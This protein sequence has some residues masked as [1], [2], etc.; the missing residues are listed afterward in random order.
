MGIS[1]VTVSLARNDPL[2][3]LHDYNEP[4]NGNL[5]DVVRL[6]LGKP[7]ISAEDRLTV[8]QVLALCSGVRLQADSHCG[9]CAMGIDVRR[10]KNVV[11]GHRSGKT[12]YSI[13]RVARIQD[14][15][16]ILRMANRFNVRS[17]VVDIRP[18]EDAA[19]MFQKKAKFKVYLCQ[20]REN[21]PSGTQ[22]QDKN[23]I[24]TCGRTEIMDATHRWIA[25]ETDLSLPADCPEV[26]Q[27][28][29]ECCNTAKVEVIDKRTKQVVYRYVKLGEEPDDYRHALNYFYLAATGGRLSVVENEF[30]TRR[31]G[32]HAVVEY[33]RN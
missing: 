3:I 31:R 6:R 15:N 22:W 19:R 28:A 4:P 29:R 10:H 1:T 32:G 21:A 5:G 27:F 20:Y 24:V 33:V 18:Y 12:R 25:E 26:K 14:W 7:Y 13:D 9:P 30:G 8:Q 17:C 11:I 16:D 23:G 2:D